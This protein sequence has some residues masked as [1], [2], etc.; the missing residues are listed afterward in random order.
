MDALTQPPAKARCGIGC[1][2]CRIQSAAA[3]GYKALK[4]DDVRQGKIAQDS[5][6][7]LR[8][9]EALPFDPAAGWVNGDTLPRRTLRT[10]EGSTAGSGRSGAPGKRRNLCSKFGRCLAAVPPILP[11]VTS[12]CFLAKFQHQIWRWR[13]QLAQIAIY[14]VAVRTFSRSDDPVSPWQRAGLLMPQR[15]DRV[16]AGRAP[17]R[18]ISEQHANGGRKKEGNQVDGRIEQVGHLHQFGQPE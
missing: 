9:G 17:G 6:Y 15:L 13:L 12:F 18:K 11:A 1:T 7:F 4:W 8:E 2:T 16:H 10:P 5:T 3:T 14:F